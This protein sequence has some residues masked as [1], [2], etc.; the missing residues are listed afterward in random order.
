MLRSQRKPIVSFHKLGGFRSRAIELRATG[1]VRVKAESSSGSMRSKHVDHE[2]HVSQAADR[3]R[4]F[5]DFDRD[6]QDLVARS[7]CSR[8]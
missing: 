7:E 8:A 2:E 4:P 1:T 5:R 3:S 6:L